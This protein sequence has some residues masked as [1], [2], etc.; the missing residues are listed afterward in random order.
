M[1]DFIP[2][3]AHPDRMPIDISFVFENEKPAGKHGFC[4]VQGDSFYFEDGTK[5]RFYGVICNGAANFPDHD[6]AEKCAKRLAQVGINY[7][8]FHQLDSEWSTPN[9]FRFSTGKTLKDTRHFDPQSMERLDYWIKCLK[10]NG[11][12]S[13]VDMTTYRKFKTGDGVK[14]ADLMMDNMKTYAH[15]DPVMIDLQKEY[16]DNF[17][18]HVN[19]YTGLAYKDDPFFLG[20]IIS[21]ENEMFK[22]HKD[23]GDYNFI[24]YYDDMFRDM[25]DKW[26]KEKGSDYDA[27]SCELLDFDDKLQIEFRIELERRYAKTMYDHIRS[28]GVKVPICDTNWA[29]C[30]GLV[31]AQEQMDFQDGHEYFY[32]WRWGEWE[33]RCQHKHLL[34]AP[35][36][37]LRGLATS[38]INGQP[39]YMTEWGMPWP[40]SFRAEGPLWFAASAAFQG[41]SG[42]SV[43]TY[44]YGTHLD[45]NMPLGKE[46]TSNC[47][48]S[49]PYREGLFSVWNDPSV[50]GLFYHA[51]LLFR[52][53]DVSEAKKTVGA[54]ITP[55]DYGKKMGAYNKFAGT[56]ME[57]HKVVSVLDTTDRTGVDEVYP[58]DS[59]YPEFD[60][61]FVKSDTGELW[62]DKKAGIAAIDTPRTKA[63]YGNIADKIRATQ[64]PQD[65]TITVDGMS[66]KAATDFGVV[67][68][69]SLNDDPIE[70]SDNLLL[71]TVGRSF[72]TGMQF[73]G[74]KLIKLGT[75][76]VEIEVIN[77]EIRIKTN[78]KTLR[79]WAINSEGFYHGRVPATWEDGWLSFHVGPNFPSQ[80]YLLMAE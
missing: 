55:D 17:W 67:A 54:L 14:Y 29:A 40:N 18:N 72:N 11:I 80:Y 23:R 39:M 38:R 10:E 28:L 47:I 58:C 48:G 62:R 51:A 37:P 5:A 35:N 43:H 44:A 26:L 49:V 76:P 9:I 32:D 64:K 45:E 57:Q 69:S 66:V 19:E 1:S 7:V 78:Q 71:T 41:W 22:N 61:K 31:K 34:T 30:G 33:K 46:A 2:T 60:E 56:A 21:N 53:G 70:T 27:Y 20:V 42:M 16:C 79:V 4:K 6:Y 3:Y 50:F 36:S 59:V 12:Y 13:C 68:L 25:F 8:R 77:A 63:I 15:Y 74:E 65:T 73:D 24:P 52:R 75:T